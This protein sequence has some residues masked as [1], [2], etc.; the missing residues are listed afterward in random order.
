MSEAGDFCRLPGTG[1][2]RDE[3]LYGSDDLVR[4]LL[5]EAKTWFV[6]GLSQNRA[7]AAYGVAEL[8]QREGR[9]VVPV[10]PRAETVLGQPGFATVEQAARELGAP[11]VVDCFVNSGLVGPVVDSAIAVGAG[12]V[13]LQFDVIDESAAR[14]ALDAGVSV[15]MDRCPAADW[16]LLGPRYT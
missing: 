12:A 14:R 10:H 16:P 7:R 1:P 15:V 6:V 5:A 13:W 3:A 9:T 8:L 11:D 4:Q 2:Q